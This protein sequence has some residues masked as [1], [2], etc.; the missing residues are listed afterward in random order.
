MDC[1]ELNNEINN[2]IEYIPVTQ[3]NIDKLRKLIDNSEIER[4][5]LREFNISQ[6]KEKIEKIL[7]RID[8]KKD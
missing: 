7:S 1:N 6:R 8:D 4:I 2:N 3:E 5:M